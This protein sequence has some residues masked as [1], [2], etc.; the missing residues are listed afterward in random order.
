[1]SGSTIKHKIVDFFEYLCNQCKITNYTLGM[2]IRAFHI[3]LPIGLIFL[4]LFAPKLIAIIILLFIFILYFLYISLNGCILTSL[5]KRLCKDDFTFIDIFLEFFDI[6]INESNQ[7]SMSIKIA[8]LYIFFSIFIIYY[9]FYLEDENKFNY[10]TFL[11][12]YLN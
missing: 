4:L 11:K 2:N 6:E 12:N 9:R 3:T 1:M 8:T 10:I 5:E 7:Y